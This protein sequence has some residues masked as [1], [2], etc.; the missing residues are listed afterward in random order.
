MESDQSREDTLKRPAKRKATSMGTDE[1]SDTYSDPDK[2]PK[3]GKTIDSRLEQDDD[4]D[5]EDDIDGIL[6]DL[7]N[8]LQEVKKGIKVDR[9]LPESQKP[10]NAHLKVLQEEYSSYFDEESQTTVEQGLKDLEVYLQDE[11]KALK[12]EKQQDSDQPF[13]T[14]EFSKSNQA[15]NLDTKEPSKTNQPSQRGDPL[16]DIPQEMPSFLDDMD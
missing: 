5:D 14:S 2:N 3:K 9:L 8:S 4:D 12:K 10:H 7:K 13:D 6:K 16:E 15:S 1:D 11:I